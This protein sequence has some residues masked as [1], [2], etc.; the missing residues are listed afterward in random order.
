MW[1]IIWSD[2]THFYNNNN[3]SWII[4]NACKV[5]RCG[6]NYSERQ[7]DIN[8]FIQINTQTDRQTDGHKSFTDMRDNTE[9][10][11]QSNSIE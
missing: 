10:F 2:P 7:K 6:I 5:E 4:L 11:S 3:D 8:L 9:Q 1:D